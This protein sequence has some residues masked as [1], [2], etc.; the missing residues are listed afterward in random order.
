MGVCGWHVKAGLVCI[1]RRG[2]VGTLMKIQG[3]EHMLTLVQAP[4]HEGAQSQRRNKTSP[5]MTELCSVQGPVQLP[6]P[7]M[8][9]QLRQP[10]GTNLCL[11]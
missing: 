5:G 9:L 4:A 6:S 11:V 8:S 2:A 10:L 7:P 3:P 1:D